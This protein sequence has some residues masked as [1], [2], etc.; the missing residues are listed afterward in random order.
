[1]KRLYLACTIM[2]FGLT[3]CW[4]LSSNEPKKESSDV[5]APTPTPVQEQRQPQPT[6]VVNKGT[7]VTLDD[8]AKS[9]RMEPKALL[10]TILSSYEAVVIDFFA[11]WC[12]PCKTLSTILEATVPA[13]KNIV[14]IKI[15]VDKFEE[16]SEKYGIR[17]MPT[18]FFFKNGKQVAK[19]GPMSAGELKKK[20]KDLYQA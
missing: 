6:V 4:P 17:S 11:T 19:T 5:Q 1:M 8:L 18:V 20:L 16:I 12:G 14:F 3:S 2:V 7:I 15:D 9:T 13:Y 10:N